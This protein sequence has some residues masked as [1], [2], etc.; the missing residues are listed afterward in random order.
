MD[1]K[2][3]NEE[4]GGVDIYILDQILKNRYQP[5]DKILD[6]GCGNGRNLKW[7]YKNGFEIFGTDINSESIEFCKKAF[8]LQENNF[9]V[10]TVE[11]N[12]FESNSFNHVICNAVL[13]FAN[14][15]SQ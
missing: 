13:H 11:Q 9:N 3:L 7:F 10:S 8:P 6:A 14:D 1:R 15:L 2:N 12:H 4:I 5:G